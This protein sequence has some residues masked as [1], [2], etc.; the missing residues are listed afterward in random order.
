[1]TVIWGTYLAHS[2][3]AE[4]TAALGVARQGLALAAQND[5]PGVSALANRFM[6]QTLNFMGAFVDARFHLERANAICAANQEAIAAYRRFGTDDQV[7]ASSFLASTLLPLGYPERSA[8]A[9]ER[10]VARARALGHAFTTTLAVSHVA[11]IGTLGYDPQRAL[12]HA[13]EAI[14]LSVEHGTRRG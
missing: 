12:A 10:S 14:A 6:G 2:M 7:M 8:A 1:M 9:A 13:D 3:R 11:F 5:H 4:H